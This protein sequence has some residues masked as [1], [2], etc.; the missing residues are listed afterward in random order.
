MRLKKSKSI[1]VFIHQSSRWRFAHRVFFEIFKTRRTNNLIS[2]RDY[3]G[4]VFIA[5]TRSTPKYSVSA[6]KN[7][8]AV[9]NLLIN[10]LMLLYESCSDEKSSYYPLGYGKYLSLFFISHIAEERFLSNLPTTPWWHPWLYSIWSRV[11]NIRLRL[12]PWAVIW[13]LSEPCS[14]L[15]WAKPGFLPLTLYFSYQ[16]LYSMYPVYLITHAR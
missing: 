9:A 8:C 3:N 11:Q 7:A 14:T 15:L 6:I 1:S 2:H 13:M 10:A 12:Y 4:A 5:C 16:N